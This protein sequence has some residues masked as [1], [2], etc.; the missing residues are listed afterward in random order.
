MTYVFSE[1][2]LR[3][4]FCQ[5]GEVFTGSMPVFAEPVGEGEAGWSSLLPASSGVL[6]RACKGHVCN[7]IHRNL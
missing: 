5:R 6:L 2:F 1:G 3:G 4:S 7:V